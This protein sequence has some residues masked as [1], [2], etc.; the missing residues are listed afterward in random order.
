MAQI[1]NNRTYFEVGE[2]FKLNGLNCVCKLQR[3]IEG[4][5]KCVLRY[6]HF[7]DCYNVACRPNERPDENFVIFI[8]K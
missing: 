1:I 6:N 3:E 7:R 4:C 2:E 8:Q 5:G